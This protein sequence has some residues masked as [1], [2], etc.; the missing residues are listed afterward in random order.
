MSGRKRKS[1]ENSSRAFSP[2]PK[3]LF[4][5]FISHF[6]ISW[7]LLDIWQLYTLWQ[8]KFHIS[9]PINLLPVHWKLMGII[10]IHH[11]KEAYEFVHKENG[12]IS[13]RECYITVHLLLQATC[14][15]I[16]NNV[17]FSYIVL[18]GDGSAYQ[19]LICSLKTDMH[20]SHISLGTL[21]FKSWITYFHASQHK[22]ESVIKQMVTINWIW[23]QE[24]LESLIKSLTHWRVVE[25]QLWGSVLAANTFMYALVSEAEANQVFRDGVPTTL[26]RAHMRSA[27]S[28]EQKCSVDCVILKESD[29]SSGLP[30]RH[31]FWTHQLCN[32]KSALSPPLL[33][34]THTHTHTH[35][36]PETYFGWLMLQQHKLSSS[37]WR[38]KQG[39]RDL[40]W[41]RCS[42]YF[43]PHFW[44]PSDLFISSLKFIGILLISQILTLSVCAELN[45]LQEECCS[46]LDISACRYMYVTLFPR[47]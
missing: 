28:E 22:P 45:L 44:Q 29:S 24:G 33:H 32:C 27:H 7:N 12:I 20:F 42:E 47:I 30:S 37:M 18:F 46:N 16:K 14:I 13:G 35:T 2:S 4:S 3:S 5:L 26:E 38:Q 19:F 31:Q 21:G 1:K 41:H 8:L 9:S 25:W 10:K 40:W 23:T 36:H 15:N 6:S 43:Q 34:H 17:F 39:T 11:H